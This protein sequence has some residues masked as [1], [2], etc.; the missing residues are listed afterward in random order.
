MNQL[1]I[2]RRLTYGAIG[3]FVLTSVSLAVSTGLLKLKESEFLQTSKTSSAK[4]KELGDLLERSKNAPVMT[5][6]RQLQAFQ[7]AFDRILEENDCKLIEIASS[8]DSGIYLSRY[9]KVGKDKGWVQISVHCQVSGRLQNI[10]D[11]IKRVSLSTMP[12]EIES[13]TFSKPV[14]KEAEGKEVSAKLT[15][16]LLNME[17]GA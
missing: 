6:K 5:G 15:V 14:G 12:I 3:V 9:H 7:G 13:I 17:G 8:G 1:L 10:V 11:A 4:L 16:N 2:Y